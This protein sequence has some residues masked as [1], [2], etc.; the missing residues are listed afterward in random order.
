MSDNG[1]LLDGHG[2]VVETGEKV[3]EGIAKTKEEV[4][5]EMRKDMCENPESYVKIKDLIAAFMLRPDG[6]PLT[7]VSPSK[8]YNDLVLAQHYLNYNLDANI[9]ARQYASQKHEASALVKPK[10]N[11]LSGIRGMGKKRR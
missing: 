4:L 7:L 6:S 11:F 10:N 5:K 3:G 9:K 8:S 2:R 1:K